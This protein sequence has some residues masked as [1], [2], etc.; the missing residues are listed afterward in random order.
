[1]NHIYLSPKNKG[2]EDPSPY[3]KLESNNNMQVTRSHDNAKWAK[4]FAIMS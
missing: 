1:M 3:W 4:F 2:N